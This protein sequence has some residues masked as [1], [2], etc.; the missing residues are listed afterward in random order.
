MGPFYNGNKTPD[1]SVETNFSFFFLKFSS[2]SVCSGRHLSKWILTVCALPAWD[3][4]ISV[5]H[6]DRVRPVSGGYIV[7]GVGLVSVVHHLHRF[8]HTFTHTEERVNTEQAN[9]RALVFTVRRRSHLWGL[10]RGPAA[11][12]LQLWRRPRWTPVGCLPWRRCPDRVPGT[13]P[14]CCP[15]CRS[16]A[17][18][19]DSLH[20]QNQ[21][22]TFRRRIWWL[23]NKFVSLSGP[24]MGCPPYVTLRL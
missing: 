8:H 2:I 23:L 24:L 11:G 16:R 14:W 7:D 20:G 9:Q 4:L 5:Q 15:R 1:H 12:P 10:E 13:S 6:I 17:P 19:T 22:E 3:L 21:E 18:W